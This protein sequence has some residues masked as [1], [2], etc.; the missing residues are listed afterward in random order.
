MPVIVQS[1]SARPQLSSIE[2]E[3]MEDQNM[4]KKRICIREEK[5]V[6]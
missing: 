4:P 2:K 6:V 5:I 1:S 3:D